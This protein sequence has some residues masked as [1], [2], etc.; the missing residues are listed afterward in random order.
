[1]LS[2][3]RLDL[4]EVTGPASAAWRE[5]QHSIASID[6]RRRTPF[7]LVAVPTGERAKAL[8]PGNE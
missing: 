4:D 1:V 5:S 2:G 8:G 6:E 3:D 7:V